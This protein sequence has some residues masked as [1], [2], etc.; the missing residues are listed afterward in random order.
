MPSPSLSAPVLWPHPQ[1]MISTDTL[2]FGRVRPSVCVER[3]LIVANVGGGAASLA[4]HLH[5]SAPWLQLRAGDGADWGPRVEMSLQSGEEKLILCRADPSHITVDW[6]GQDAHIEVWSGEANI[7]NAPESQ[8]NP[9]GRLELSPVKAA[10]YFLE[11]R[12]LQLEALPNGNADQNVVAAGSSTGRCEIEINSSA[13]TL[14]TSPTVTLRL[15]RSDALP[16][17]AELGLFTLQRG[18][19]QWFNCQLHSRGNEQTLELTFYTANREPGKTHTIELE[20]RD[21]DDLVEP[22]KIKWHLSVTRPP[23][24]EFAPIEARAVPAVFT[25]DTIELKN[26][27]EGDLQVQAIS[28]PG[29]HQRWLTLGPV[30]TPFS[31]AAG[32]T[33]SIDIQVSGRYLQAGQQH[34]GCVEVSCNHAGRRVMRRIPVWAIAPAQAVRVEANENDLQAVLTQGTS[35]SFPVQIC[36][37]SAQTASLRMMVLD[38]V[39]GSDIWAYCEP[40]L[41]TLASGEE[42]QATVFLSS[43]ALSPPEK[44][45]T[46]E[47]NGYVVVL[48]NEPSGETQIWNRRISL[49]VQ[50]R[51]KLL[52]LF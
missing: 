30:Q 40:S 2:D 43:E 44:N 9:Q 31:I 27:G 5:C 13:V 6:G 33:H 39:K 35:S 28:V 3:A 47:K 15:R 7:L 51:R 32:A 49:R 23:L 10:A 24:L 11:P 48:L 38:A 42:A 20:V 37:E 34:H 41:F 14:G 19:E 8:L 4:I 26:V 22:A 52:G 25:P 12:F 17:R 21:A 46:L 29:Q 18:K 16:T 45:G 50:P 36:N 1:W